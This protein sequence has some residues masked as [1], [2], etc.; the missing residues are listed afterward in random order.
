M[1]QQQETIQDVYNFLPTHNERR[2][3]CMLPPG[4]HLDQ[5]DQ[6]TLRGNPYPNV[7]ELAS[8]HE[9]NY[10]PQLEQLYQTHPAIRGMFS[11]WRGTHNT[12]MFDVRGG[13][14]AKRGPFYGQHVVGRPASAETMSRLWMSGKVL[15]CPQRAAA[16]LDPYTWN[17]PDNWQQFYH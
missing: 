2:G 16:N 11:A 8:S 10:L 9:H 12:R 4:V 5:T 7:N 3:C 15:E 6:F 17:L 13:H 14:D 1:A